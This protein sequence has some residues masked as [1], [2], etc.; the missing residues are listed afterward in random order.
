M[1][2]NYLLLHMFALASCVTFFHNSCLVNLSTKMAVFASDCISHF[3]S[4]L[5]GIQQEA[6]TQH[7]LQSYIFQMDWSIK[8]A[9]GRSRHFRLLRRNCS[10][11]FDETWQ[12]TST[13]CL[14]STIK[15]LFFANQSTKMVA[16]VEQFPTSLQLLHRIWRRSPWGNHH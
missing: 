2:L 16:L 1:T 7:P 13:Q 15:V 10:T 8:I 4:P 3:T 9:T 14:L 6:N 5:N 11:S 12:E